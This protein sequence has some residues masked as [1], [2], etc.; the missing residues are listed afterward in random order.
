MNRNYTAIVVCAAC[1]RVLSAQ[2]DPPPCPPPAAKDIAGGA[3]A[4]LGCEWKDPKAVQHTLRALQLYTTPV[5][6]TPN[7]EF[8]GTREATKLALA[9]LIAGDPGHEDLY[10][11]A[12]GQPDNDGQPDAQGQSNFLDTLAKANTLKKKKPED[13]GPLFQEARILIDRIFDTQPG[14]KQALAKINDSFV[15]KDNHAALYLLLSAYPA[16]DA[17]QYVL[18]LEILR[19]AY[20]MSSDDLALLVS[21]KISGPKE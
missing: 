8:F 3:K 18:D 17:N 13:E 20:E 6:K 11:G 2:S 9:E 16:Y 19:A 21:K 10:R 5:R 1:M 4:A 15:R 7:G 14:G 12:Q